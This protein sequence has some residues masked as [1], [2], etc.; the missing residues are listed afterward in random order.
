V[1]VA[2]LGTEVLLAVNRRYLPTSPA[3]ELDGRFGPTTAPPLRFVVLGDSTGAGVGASTRADTYP[4]RLA[5]ALG[6]RD[7]R[8]E[9]S[10]FAVSGARV[11]D[12]LEEQV[13]RA[14]EVRP[15]LV[16]V[17]IGGNDAT[18]ATGLG[19][20]RRDMD[21]VI[22][23]LTVAGAAV[24]VSGPGDMGCPN[25]LPPLRQIVA[26]RGRRVEAVIAESANAHGVPLVPLRARTAHLFAADPDRYFSEDLFHPGSEGYAAWAEAFLPEVLRTAGLHR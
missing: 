22:E 18:H 8:V 2:V 21:L 14:L 7:R 10:V 11:H 1:A 15:D 3:L 5:R 13:P 20:L 9:L 16:L 12:V 25:F 24:V 6:E 26:W 23:R 19:G 4:W 17:A